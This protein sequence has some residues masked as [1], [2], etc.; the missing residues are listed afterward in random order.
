MVA[1]VYGKNQVRSIDLHDV[2]NGISE[3][4]AENDYVYYFSFE[5]CK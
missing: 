1:L 4:L 2:T 3:A 5:F